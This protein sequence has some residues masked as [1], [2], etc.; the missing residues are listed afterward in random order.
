MLIGSAKEA[1]KRFRRW[2]RA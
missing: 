2:L 1:A